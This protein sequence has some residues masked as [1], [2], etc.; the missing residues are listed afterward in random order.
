M[1]A[2][3]KFNILQKNHIKIMFQKLTFK[4]Q[5]ILKFKNKNEDNDIFTIISQLKQ[6]IA[7]IN[8]IY[9]II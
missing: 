9:L 4:N 8:T 6:I 3:N 5:I 7:L 2:F 1:I